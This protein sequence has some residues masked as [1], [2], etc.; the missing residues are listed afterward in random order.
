MQFSI[1]LL[2]M[3]AV[4]QAF[5]FMAPPSSVMLRSTTSLNAVK[6]DPPPAL[7]KAEFVALVAEKAGL[8]KVHAEAALAAVIDTITAEVAGGKKISILGFGTFKLTQRQARMGRN[9]KTGEPISIKASKSPSF[10]S[11]KTFKEK[12]N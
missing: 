5:T 12:C 2:G 11:S 6:P 1:L 8:S 4:S 7:K 3:A 10:S 9:P